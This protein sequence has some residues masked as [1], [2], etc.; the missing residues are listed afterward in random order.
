MR[1]CGVL[2]KTSTLLAT[3]STFTSL[4][5]AFFSSRPV[6]AWRPKQGLF[7]S[8]RLRTALRKFCVCAPLYFFHTSK[9]L[10]DIC[11]GPLLG[12]PSKN[13]AWR[14]KAQAREVK[15]EPVARRVDVLTKH[16]AL[17]HAGP[18]LCSVIFYATFLAAIWRACTVTT[19]SGGA[20]SRRVEQSTWATCTC[21]GVEGWDGKRLLPTLNG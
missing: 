9:R 18:N 3:G 4:A 16:P 12:R 8:L 14:E 2:V 6:F 13:G 10:A 19:T 17:A 20:T 7:E 15:V 1:E 21:W 11:H 5:C